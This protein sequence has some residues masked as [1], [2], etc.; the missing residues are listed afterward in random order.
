MEKIILRHFIMKRLSRLL[1]SISVTINRGST[2]VPS[3]ACSNFNISLAAT[4]GRVIVL[5]HEQGGDM[6]L[7]FKG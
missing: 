4:D 3:V 2:A 6:Y 1:M 7:Y 5:Y